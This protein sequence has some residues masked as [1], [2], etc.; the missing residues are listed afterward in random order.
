[1]EKLIC[2]KWGDDPEVSFEATISQP[3]SVLIRI[4]D[5]EA[6]VSREE[7]AACAALWPAK[8]SK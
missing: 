6:L 5:V 2:R 1:M 4:G 8:I 7:I 3:S